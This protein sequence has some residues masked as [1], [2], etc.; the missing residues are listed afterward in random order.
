MIAALA[1]LAVSTPPHAL[2]NTTDLHNYNTLHFAAGAPVA[3]GGKLY[4]A[5]RPVSA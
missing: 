3:E 1:H 2:L 4:V 5:T